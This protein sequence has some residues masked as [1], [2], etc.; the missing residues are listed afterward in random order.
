MN[1]K[2]NKYT[3][4]VELWYDDNEVLNPFLCGKMPIPERDVWRDTHQDG[5]REGFSHKEYIP[6]YSYQRGWRWNRKRILTYLRDID[7]EIY[8]IHFI[9]YHEHALRE[10]L[11]DKHFRDLIRE[12]GWSFMY[13]KK[14]WSNE[15]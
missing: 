12:L 11:G 14:G 3:K 7:R 6:V 5:K 15:G 9:L 8:D 10:V 4:Y 2:Q 13:K 1:K